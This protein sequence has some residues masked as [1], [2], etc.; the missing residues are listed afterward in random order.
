MRGCILKIL[1]F[2]LLLTVSLLVLVAILD[3]RDAAPKG[4]GSY[5][6][7]DR[8]LSEFSNIKRDYAQNQLPEGFFLIGDVDGFNYLAKGTNSHRIGGGG[9]TLGIRFN[10]GSIYIFFGH[11]CGGGPNPLRLPGSNKQELLEGL[12]QH[13]TEYVR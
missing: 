10:D 13:W 7:A 9:G 2:G 8:L 3:R 12:R 4:E 6:E 11:V 5:R 1:L